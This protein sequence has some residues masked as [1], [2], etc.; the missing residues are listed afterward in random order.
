MR[1]LALSPS[2]LLL[3]EFTSNL[4]NESVMLM[5]KQVNDAKKYG[6]AI[7]LVSHDSEQIKRLSDEVI[8]L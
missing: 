6:T 8:E 1:T 2:L 7:V 5:E 3:D 4:D